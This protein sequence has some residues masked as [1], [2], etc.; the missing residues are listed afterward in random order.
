M[1]SARAVLEEL[2]IKVSQASLPK[3]VEE[4]L[5]NLLKFTASGAEAESLIGYVNF[6][7]SLPFGKMSQD[8]LDIN[9]AKQIL[10]KNHYGL[11]S[12]KDRI[13]EYLAVMILNKGRPERSGDSL[14]VE[15]HA[16]ILAFIGLVGTGKTSLAYS[17]A[18]SLG[19]PL[20]RIP[21]GGLGDP[22][23]LRGSSRIRPDAEPG[24]IIK[25][26]QSTKVSN[27]VILL[28]EIDRAAVEHR[29]DI[30]G[31][32]VELLDPAQNQAFTDHYLDFPYDLSQV[33]FIATANNTGNIATAVLDR[34]EPIVMPSY[35]DEEKLIIGKNYLLP[36]A[37][38]E[39]GINGDLLSID[40]A[41]WPQILRPL[42]FDSG[43]RS[44]SRSLQSICRKIARK[45]VEGGTGPFRITGDNLREYL[46]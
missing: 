36:K 39:A 26:V 32:L 16:P 33:L 10:D 1:D 8:I 18:E 27:P 4:K 11:Q 5:L 21:F 37:I 15:G 9:R 6:V 22:S 25:A 42:G 29:V 28:D 2:K 41:V 7:I 43:I 46:S 40:E 13:L 31:V 45:Q 20:V 23:A 35:S 44:L 34:L 17:I 12:V 3:E 19:R 14:R 38:S 30:M 24:Q